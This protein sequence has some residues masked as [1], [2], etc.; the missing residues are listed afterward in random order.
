MT[1]TR[2]QRTR[3]WRMPENTVY[4]GRG[5]KWSNPYAVGK[6]APEHVAAVVHKGRL[7]LLSGGSTRVRDRADAVERF[8]WL[9]FEPILNRPDYPPYPTRAEIKAE[10]AG[11][12]LACW[13][14]LDKPCH[15]DVLLRIANPEPREKE[16][17]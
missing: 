10:L 3:G 6:E 17:A 1:P 15:T 14:P 12:N 8:A 16:E 4:V 7:H 9:V 2:V 5:S 13:C 11:K